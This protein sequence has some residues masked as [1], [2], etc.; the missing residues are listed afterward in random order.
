MSPDER[1]F[2]AHLEEASFE[3]GVDAGKWGLQGEAKDVVWPHAVLWVAADTQLYAP[4]KIYL[5]FDL[6]GYPVAAPTACPWN[7]GTNQRLE[8][9]AWPKLTGKCKLVFRHDWQIKNALYAPCDRLAMNGHQ[10]PW[11]KQFPMWWWQPTF[12]I[13]KYLRFVHL[14]LNPNRL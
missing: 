7:V 4:G 11:E 14:C 9:A 2:K 8:D 1:L 10:N 12:T 6:T 5:R 13:V 3:S